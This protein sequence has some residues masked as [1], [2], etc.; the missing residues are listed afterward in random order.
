MSKRPQKRS[1]AVQPAE[2]EDE[3]VKGDL[4][5][6]SDE[7]PAAHDVDDEVDAASGIDS[8]QS[9]EDELKDAIAE[10]MEAAAAQRPADAVGDALEAGTSGDVG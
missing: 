3:P 1:E 2:A 7:E 4:D 5:L 8:V 10:Y 6:S 9:D